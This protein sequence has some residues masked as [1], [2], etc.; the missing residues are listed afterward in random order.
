MSTNTYHIHITG[1]VQGVG[2]RPFV[3]KLAQQL[4][5]TGWVSNDNDGVHIE[6]NAVDAIANQ[7]YEKIVSLHP[8]NAM[9]HRHHIS[10]VDFLEYKKFEIVKIN[11]DKLPDLFLTPDIA[12]CDACKTELGEIGNRRF[13]Y[14]FTTCLNCGPR[15]SI[16]SSLP[17]DREN[18]TMSELEMC[19][20]CAEEYNDV[21][22]RRHYSQTNSCPDCAV[23]I[24]MYDKGGHIVSRNPKQ[25]IAKAVSVLNAGKIIAVKGIGGYLLMCDATNAETIKRL[26]QLKHRPYKPFA[27]MY[28]SIEDIKKDVWLN[29]FEE[30]TLQSKEAPIVL[31]KI[32]KETFA[33][34]QKENIANGLN[35]LGVFLPYSPLLKLITSGF[36]K[37]IVATS[38]NVSGSPI[39]Y[40]D[41]EALEWLSNF[42]DYIIAFDRDIV[43]PQD[44]SVLQFASSGK[45]IILRRSRGYAPNYIPNL[46]EGNKNILAMGAD[47]KAAFAI[48]DKR[49]L[50]IS[51]FLG[52]L[53]GYESQ[54]SY[55]A[56]LRHLS[57]LLKFKP[58]HI[59][60]DAHPAYQSNMAG[61]KFATKD[62]ISINTV[63]H[64]KAHFAA[65][66]QENNVTQSKDKILGV[67][68]DGTGYGD[69]GQIWGGEFFVWEHQSME[70]VFNLD[71]FPQI[72]SD[73]MSKEPRLSA[74]CLLDTAKINKDIIK[75]FFNNT[76]WDFYGKMVQ[77]QNLL[78]SS[79][80]RL[81]DGVACLLG[82]TAVN[83]YEGEA[84][85]RLEALA[86]NCV[87]ESLLPFTVIVEKG[88]VL[89]QQM[90]AEIVNLVK[91]EF[92]QKILA[93]RFFITLVAMLEKVAS[94]MGIHKIAF[95]GGVFQNKLLV[96]LIEERLNG[97]FDLFFHQ[98]LS[99]NDE[100]ISFGQIAYHQIKTKIV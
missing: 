70:R 56:S 81:I 82:I 86:E 94:E 5:L 17:Y 4:D 10:K 95:S 46:F 58:E 8:I 15:Y 60:I 79:M 85:M 19:V 65:V 41:V 22:D 90:I 25:I 71:Y 9:V 11:S 59:L 27:V 77:Q 83:S 66:L 42:S 33:A 78:T 74:L 67:I 97:K 55:H 21:F 12:I 91:E 6:F 84:A 35:R 28:D 89:W 80:G 43:T 93:K 44:D 37:P 100:C 18:T 13:L 3:Y 29:E 53:G 57:S 34:L 48:Y 45:K 92:D 64:H 14:P 7:F 30:D 2:F 16:V 54:Q 36:I 47:M 32:K 23:P 96:D 63:Q 62:N 73:K 49:N 98:Q 76:E 72:M 99:P 61:N 31:C 26:R 50:F 69:D 38:G 39:I 87:E 24:H 20:T 88:H 75:P 68:W 52:D 51:Q 40:K 1:I